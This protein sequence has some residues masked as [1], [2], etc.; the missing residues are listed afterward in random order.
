[1]IPALAVQQPGLGVVT[2]DNLNTY[3][4]GGTLLANLQSF[5]G[6]SGMSCYLVGYTAIGDG[7]QGM[8]TWNSGLTS[9]NNTTTILPFGSLLGGWQRVS[10][11]YPASVP[12]Q[13]VV[14]LTGFSVTITPPTRNLV[15]N[16]AGTLAAGGVVFPPSP[17]DGYKLTISTTQIITALTLSGGTIS[18]PVTTLAA[19]GKIS[20]IWVAGASSWFPG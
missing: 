7:G 15:L 8:W 2:A 5:T 17:P 4:Q 12:Y 3:I 1:M 9:G 14:P 6:I 10:W 16:P 20:Y 11:D 13:Y 18:N 19:G